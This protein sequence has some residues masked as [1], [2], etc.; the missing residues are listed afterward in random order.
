MSSQDKMPDPAVI[1]DL[2][3]RAEET[4]HGV[5]PGAPVP[6]EAVAKLHALGAEAEVHTVLTADDADTKTRQEIQDL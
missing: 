4:E 6:N 5:V 2:K 1:A 3:R